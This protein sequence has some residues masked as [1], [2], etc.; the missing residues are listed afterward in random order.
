MNLIGDVKG[1]VAILVDDMIDTAGMFMFFSCTSNLRIDLLMTS[2]QNPLSRNYHKCSSVAA[3]R[4]CQR[5]NR[6]LHTCCFQV[7]ISFNCYFVLELLIIVFVCIKATVISVLF[8]L[9]LL[10]S[11][12]YQVDSFRK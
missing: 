8:L 12:D 5:S 11:R 6:V 10:Q 9:V 3:E 4:R 2:T 7:R 1:K